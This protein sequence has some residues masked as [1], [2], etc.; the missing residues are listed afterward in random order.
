MPYLGGAHGEVR[1]GVRGGVRGAV[2]EVRSAA[3]EIRSA[4]GDAPGVH[5][6]PSARTAQRSQRPGPSHSSVD[7]LD[8]GVRFLVERAGT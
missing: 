7:Q 1:G 2:V 6:S 4:A 8:H 3:G 5:S